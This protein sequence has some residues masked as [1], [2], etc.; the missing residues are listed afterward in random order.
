MASQ[1]STGVRV[2]APSK[3]DP[4]HKLHCEHS[5]GHSLRLSLRLCCIVWQTHRHTKRA[6]N[7][8]WL[9]RWAAVRRKKQPTWYTDPVQTKT[10]ME[11]VH[12]Q[13]QQRISL[14][15]TCR[16]SGFMLQHLPDYSVWQAN[17]SASEPL[18]Q[19]DRHTEPRGIELC[20]L[21]AFCTASHLTALSTATEGTRSNAQKTHTGR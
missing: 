21:C 14:R 11:N 1:I 13:N 3:L 12:N 18:R 20:W 9:R 15:H 2:H 7:P 5:R 6:V 19:T 4:E 8:C 16:F 17:R 10:H